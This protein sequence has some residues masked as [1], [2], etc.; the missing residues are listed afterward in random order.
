MGRNVPVSALSSANLANLISIK[1]F[2]STKFE[3][4]LNQ[5]YEKNHSLREGN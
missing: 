5:S 1:Q 4:V 2:S 3:N